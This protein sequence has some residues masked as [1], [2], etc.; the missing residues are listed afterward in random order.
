MVTLVG[1]FCPC[2]GQRAHTMAL[3]TGP[4]VVRHDRSWTGTD[5][6]R[7][8]C[9]QE[10]VAVPSATGRS[11]DLVPVQGRKETDETLKSHAERWL[12]ERNAQ[13]MAAWQ[14][15]FLQAEEPEREDEP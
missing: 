9:R 15:V 5:G 12:A 13:A 2:C 1:V 11:V 8:H 7:M 10:W 4:Q 14:R 6:R 3:E